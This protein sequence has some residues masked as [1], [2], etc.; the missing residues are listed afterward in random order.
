MKF[1]IN[2]FVNLVLGALFFMGCNENN[3]FSNENDILNT[4]Y[5]STIEKTVVPVSVPINSPL[6]LPYEISKYSEFGY[7][8]WRYGPGI[9]Y[10][11]RF[12]LMT[13]GYNDNGVEKSGKLLKFFAMTDIHITD[14]ESPSQSIYM[15]MFKSGL[16]NNSISA[17]SGIMLY[18]PHMLNAA[19][20]VINTIHK[21]SPIDFGIC[22]GDATNSAQYNELR[23]YIDIFDGKNINPDSGTKDDPVPGPNNDYQD[24]FR[25]EGLNS[26]IPW[27]Q[28]LGNHD[29]FWMGVKPI[30]SYLRESYT[31]NEIIKL[32]NI[33]LPGGMNAR[34]Y[35]MGVLDG[36]KVYGDVY[37]A[38]PVKDFVSVPQVAADMNRRPVSTKE[39]MS[40]FFNS[41]SK[42]TGHGFSQ[43]NIAD[44]FACYS[45]EPKSNIPIKVIVLDNTIE[46]NAPGMDFNSN[47]YGYG[48]INKKR[49]DW[50][51]NELNEGQKNNKLMIIASHI[52]IGVEK[53]GSTLGMWINSYV[54][55]EGLIAELQKYPNLILWIAG[56]R[57]V[58]TVVPF[59]SPDKNRPE[60]G[61]WGVE[62]ASL[63]EYPQLFRTFDIIKNNNNTISIIATNVEPEA[64]AGSFAEISRS[65]SIAAYQIFKMP[66]NPV[67][68]AELVVPL[69]PE[70]QKH[71][72]KYGR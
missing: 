14:K 17:Y 22:L 71:I 50:L 54:S 28:V 4:K 45:F 33:L 3:R 55:E 68:N 63:R 20:K 29:H 53:V 7:G 64:N 6:I 19:I 66:Y 70:M 1:K 5:N 46:E 40:E 47:I 59:K 9:N 8:V 31:S 16:G 25:A 10:D 15:A 69:S 32:G 34:D 60:L 49:F 23:W 13:S 51:V 36:S 27:Y 21:Q 65:Y 72:Q 18:T 42:P 61:F 12:D 2:L 38:G 56:H 26:S 24:E 44:D 57:H 43:Q 39:F 58:N 30:N 35:Y 41:T 62:T 52:P 67:Y 48:Y 11:K 37:G